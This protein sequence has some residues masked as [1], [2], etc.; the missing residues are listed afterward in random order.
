[1]SQTLEDIV[2]SE[3]ATLGYDLF[4]LQQRGSR[5]RPVIEVRIDRVSEDKITVDDCT[6]ASRAIEARLDG[7]GVVAENY[8]LEVSSP[9]VERPLR[10]AAD[11]RRFVGRRA[12]VNSPALS[13]RV[14]A[15][16]QAVEGDEGAEVAVLR[17]DQGTERRVPLAEVKDARLAFHWKR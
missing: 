10:H 1:M 12:S 9:G 11:W 16:I 13:G 17:D 14:E 4:D 3:L 15:E 5:S 8:V 2:K 6:R 7:S